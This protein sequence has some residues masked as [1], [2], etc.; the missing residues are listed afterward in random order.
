[1]PA[2]VATH[3]DKLLGPHYTWMLGG[4]FDDLVAE[5]Q[6]LL[7]AH[8]AGAGADRGARALDLG[9]GSGIQT[10]ALARLGY[11]SVVGIDISETLIGELEQRAAGHP[12]ISAVTADFSAGLPTLVADQSF[13]T[14][15]CMGDTLPHLP[16]RT[17]VRR[18]VEQT[19]TALAPGG[20]LVLSFRDLSAVLT[21]LDRFI[22]VRADD[23][24][25]MTCFLEDEGETVRVH[26]LIHTRN[27]DGSW[28]LRTGTYRKLRLSPGHVTEMLRST[29]FT[30]V[31]CSAGPRGMSVITARR[32][33][34]SRPLQARL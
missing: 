30:T 28:H 3:Y 2:E 32:P 9:C 4:G 23:D 21:G 13:T 5:Q 22:P 31:E 11:G 33:A 1:M 12:A 14:A 27:A 19:F 24:R 6:T 17:A 15:V 10:I 18:V 16:D 25:I 29:G 26:D 7:A 34:T 8:G 20:L